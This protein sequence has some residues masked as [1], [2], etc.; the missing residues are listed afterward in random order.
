MVT[1][2]QARIDMEF[3]NSRPEFRRFLWRVIQ[4]AG[5]LEP[6]TDGSDTRHPRYFEGRRN[7]G[8]EIL[9]DAEQGQPVPHPDAIPVFTAIQILREVAQQSTSETP[10]NANRAR[11]DR[12]ADLAPDDQD[13]DTD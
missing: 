4:M 10:K 1:D 3:L 7:L 5:I 8:L 11:Y 13:A 6:S 12:N 9:A 2:K